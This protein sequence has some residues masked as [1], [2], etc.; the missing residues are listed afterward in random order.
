MSYEILPTMK[1]YEQEPDDTCQL[2]QGTANV[3]MTAVD[4][5]KE[6]FL[7]ALH[8]VISCLYERSSSDGNEAGIIR[9]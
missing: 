3:T 2:V 5:D 7:S 8:R 4:E 9:P 6:W 1:F